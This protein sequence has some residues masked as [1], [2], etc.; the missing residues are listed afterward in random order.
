VSKQVAAGRKKFTITAYREKTG[1]KASPQLL[2]LRKT[3]LEINGKI[4]KSLSAG[5]KT[6]PELAKDTGYP[7]R[8]VLWYLMTLYKYSLV[9][10]AG[11]TDE[12]YYRYSLREKK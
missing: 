12:G 1:A 5:P 8:T 10:P 6:V 11:K 3:Q 4:A 9:S 2:Q 7:P